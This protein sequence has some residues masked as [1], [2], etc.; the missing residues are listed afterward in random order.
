MA[1]AEQ[2]EGLPLQGGGGGDEP[3]AGQRGVGGGD[4]VQAD[5]AQVGEQ[6]GEAVHGQ[7]GRGVL[8]GGLGQCARGADG[9]GDRAEAGRRWAACLSS[10]GEQQG[11]EAVLHVPADVVRQHPQEHVRA[12]PVLGAV[13][14]GPD[15]Q[16]GIEGPEGA[17][18]LGQGLV[19][20]DDAA[21][22]QARRASTL[23]RST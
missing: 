6:G 21:A 23:V 9:G 18:H 11:R 15:V 4:G 19:G 10:S 8:G 2:I 17:L 3:E 7:G 14:D 20:G 13:P 16:V 22:V 1:D 12:D 5:G